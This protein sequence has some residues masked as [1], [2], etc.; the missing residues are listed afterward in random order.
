M[1]YEGEAPAGMNVRY[2]DSTFAAMAAYAAVAAL[3]NRRRGGGGQFIDVSAVETMSAMIGDT[4]VDYA[5]NGTEPGCGGNRHPEMAP[6][7]VYPCKDGE[8]LS[9]A[10]AG[11]AG[12]QALAGLMGR[13]EL[14]AGEFATLADRKAREDEL[15]RLIGEWTAGRSA[16]ELVEDLQRVGVAAAKSQTSLD[17]IADATLW[18]REFYR[19]VDTGDGD[20][21]AI[22]GSA[23]RMSRPAAIDRAAPRLGEHNDYILGDVLGLSA[24]ERERLYD[25]GA[26]R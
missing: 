1:G 26:T 10:V 7:G 13:P 3:L 17:L 18:A 12:W 6:H 23:W 16:D 2:A 19:E 8:W 4:L 11:D 9:L 22:L 20:S 21:R 25:T 15:D 5:L 14:A 24:E